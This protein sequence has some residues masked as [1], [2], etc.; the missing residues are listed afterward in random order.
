MGVLRSTKTGCSSYAALFSHCAGPRAGWFLGFQYV[1][2]NA[3]DAVSPFR[4]LDLMF[5]PTLCRSYFR[6]HALCVWQW[7]LCQGLHLFGFCFFSYFTLDP[8]YVFRF[9]VGYMVFIGDFVPPILALLFPEE[10]W[11]KETQGSLAI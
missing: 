8:K 4:S 1:A 6:C 9:E 7:C 3:M 2:M 11:A 10:E 5:S